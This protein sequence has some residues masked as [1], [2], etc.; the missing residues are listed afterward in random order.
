MTLRLNN[1]ECWSCELPFAFNLAKR[2]KDHVYRTYCPFCNAEN[3]V[4]LKPNRKQT[5]IVF[6]GGAE[7]AEDSTE[8]KTELSNEYDLPETLQGKKPED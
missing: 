5:D 6:R 8:T 4:D 7:N 3:I 1:I 2:Q